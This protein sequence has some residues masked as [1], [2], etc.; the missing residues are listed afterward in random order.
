MKHTQGRWLALLLS[1]ALLLG[2]SPTALA[3]GTEEGPALTGVMLN[4]STMS[5]AVGQSDTLSA[6]LQLSDGSTLESLP[7]G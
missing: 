3:A 4:H 5:M 1:L 7:T 2:L 6:T